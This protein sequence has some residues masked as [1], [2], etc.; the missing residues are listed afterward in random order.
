MTDSS[1]QLAVTID[2]EDWYHIPSVCGSPFSVYKNVEEFFLHWNGRYDYLSDPTHRVLKI[3]KQHN[4]RATFFIVA[5][6]AE[7]YPGLV[8]SIVDDGH[9][10]AC[11]GLHHDCV[12]D[13]ATKK[14]LMDQGTF[15]RNTRE[16]KKILER[17]AGER[18]LG[19]RAPNAFIAGWMVD[20]L[21]NLA[22]RYDS[23]VSVNSLFN[24]SDSALTGVSTYPYHPQ[25]NSLVSGGPPDFIEFP[26]SYWDIGGFKIPTSGGPMLR[27][28]GSAIILK[29][30]Q[31]SLMKGPTIFYFH[32]LD[33]SDEP[34][35]HVGN[36]R[37]FYWSVKG[38]IVEDRIK[39]ILKK[40]SGY[41]RNCV[42]DI[43]W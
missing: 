12:I 11:H 35:P 13:P 33:L 8:E 9:E 17:I 1:G 34:F 37:P 7:H 16:A 40:L 15:E 32:P 23:S 28:L 5:D 36:R 21:K 31:Q 30:L 41:E 20:S 6:I 18:V 14:P 2:I 27:F 42:K 22:F 19:Y 25:I 26:L 3:L 29:G 10:I 24:K 43:L 39:N 4:I 38:K